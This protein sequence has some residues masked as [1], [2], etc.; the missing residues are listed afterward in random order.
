[1]ASRN[2]KRIANR[3]INPI[4]L[5]SVVINQ[6]NIPLNRAGAGVS[7]NDFA[8]SIYASQRLTIPI[9]A[10]PIEQQL[11]HETTVSFPLLS[12]FD[13]YIKKA[14]NPASRIKMAVPVILKTLKT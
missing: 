1:M 4:R 11:Y 3:Y 12:L 9:Q 13:G 8:V 2:Q 14:I 10:D 6:D 5:W 7:K